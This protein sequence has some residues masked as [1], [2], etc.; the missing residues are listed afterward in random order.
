MKST[1][2]VFLICSGLGRVQRGFESFTQE[3]FEALSKEPAL[4]LT[5]FKGGGESQGKSIALRNFARDGWAAIQLSKLFKMERRNDPYFVEQASF[6]VSLL[7]HLYRGRPDVIYFSDPTLGSL[8]WLW[9]HKTRQRYKLLLSNGEPAMPDFFWR[10]NHVQQVAPTH[11]RIAVEAGVPTEK[12]SLVPYGIRMPRQLQILA[13]EE[14]EALRRRLQLPEKQPIMLSVGTINKSHKR[15]DYVIQEV[16]RLS[17]P[18]PY[19]LLLGQQDKESPEITNLGNRSLGVDHFQVRTV[20][21]HEVAD[22]YRAA[23]AFVLASFV[24]GLPR[25]LIEA[26]SHGLPC[27]THDYEVTRYALEEDGYRANFALSESLT[28]LAQHVLGA[29]VNNESKR[30]ARHRS[31]YERF[32]WERLRPTYVEMIQHCAANAV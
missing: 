21:Q 1:T 20:A 30:P 4:D 29:E 10:W 7:P 19:L 14:R 25:V 23:D 12:Q 32:S 18:R 8:L 16:A 11:L 2:K 31:V 3:C 13:S 22:Y 24:E 5:V 6:F 28:R 17:G 15:M 9:R 27:L 26:M